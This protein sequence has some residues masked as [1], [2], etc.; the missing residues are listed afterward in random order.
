MGKYI[1]ILACI[2]TI[3]QTVE[4][5]NVDRGNQN[6]T[7]CE[8]MEDCGGGMCCHIEANICKPW[9]DKFCS[10][11]MISISLKRSSFYLLFRV[12]VQTNKAKLDKSTLLQILC[13]SE[14]HVT[15]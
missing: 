13:E 2:L 4:G 12:Y 11:V 9:W 3:L 7:I 10:T 6:V 8:V 15:L 14:Y 5:S 1:S